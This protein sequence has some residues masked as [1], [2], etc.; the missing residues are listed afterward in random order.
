[1]NALDRGRLAW[2]GF[3]ALALVGGTALGW[4][5]ALLDAIARPPALVRAALVAGAVVLALWLLAR[6]ISRLEA[7]RGIPSAR[8]TSADLAGLVRGV[9]Y[10]FLA[11]AALS[12]ASGW[13]VGHPLPF[14]IALVIA[15]VDV[16]ETTFL[17][18]VVAL[19]RDD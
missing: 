10:V 13:L 15:G 8:M 9:R 18:L 3:G 7:S 11:V 4:N 14:V 1:V 6:A 2:L 5:S 17:L 19:R 16:L 12:A